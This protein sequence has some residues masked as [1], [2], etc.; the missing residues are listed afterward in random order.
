MRLQNGSPSLF[1]STCPLRVAAAHD[2]GQAFVC[3]PSHLFTMRTISSSNEH[4]QAL[5]ACSKVLCPGW[6]AD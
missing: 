4:Q 3:V 6:A 5:S 1:L 2:L